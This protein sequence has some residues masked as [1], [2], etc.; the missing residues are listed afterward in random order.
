MSAYDHDLEAADAEAEGMPWNAEDGAWDFDGLDD[1]D[2]NYLAS[3]EFDAFNGPLSSVSNSPPPELEHTQAPPPSAVP[4]TT[5]NNFTRPAAPN[6]TRRSL[7]NT[8]SAFRRPLTTGSQSPRRPEIRTTFEPQRP[9]PPRSPSSFASDE[10]A[11]L[12]DTSSED[13]SVPLSRTM[14]AST[15]RNSRRGAGMVDLT[16]DNTSTSQAARG[17][18]RK[19]EASSSAGGGPAT[20]RRGSMKKQ[21]VE[22]ID[23][24]HDTPSGEEELLQQQRQDALKTQQAAMR[25]AGPQK[26]GK[27]QCI[28]CLDNITNCTTTVCGHFYCHEC[29]V[30]AL[31]HAE[32]SSDRGVGTCPHCRKPL[33]RTKKANSIVPI[34]F[35]KKAQFAKNQRKRTDITGYR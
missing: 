32:R 22:E 15:R 18:K 4:D 20:K 27:R 8:L 10:F 25:D 21:D 1:D 24:A 13:D 11:D 17:T 30:S 31:N 5:T 33:P 28:I 34:Q 26:I 6:I 12:V 14:P 29:L 7:V 9:S 2:R 16:A 35:M 19:A 3:H 23:L